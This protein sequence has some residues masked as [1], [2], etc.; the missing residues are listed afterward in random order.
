MTELLTEEIIVNEDEDTMKG[1][2]LT[3]MLGNDYYGIEISYVIEIVR[4]QTITEMPEFPKFIRGIINLRGKIIP[5]MDMRLRFKKLFREYTDRTCVIVIEIEEFALGM[6]V[7]SVAEV[8]SI[9][10]AEI[11]APPEFNQGGNKY[12]KGIGKV[13]NEVKLIIDCE[14]LLNETEINE[15]SSIN[16]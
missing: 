4:I 7:D 13:G 5:M 10:E 14:R 12:I 15:L 8:L 16:G 6:I 2:F 11:I 9:D 1:R 3:F